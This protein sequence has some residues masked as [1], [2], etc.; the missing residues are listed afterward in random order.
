MLNTLFTFLLVIFSVQYSISQ[1]GSIDFYNGTWDN[2]TPGGGWGTGSV[3]TTSLGCGGNATV[4]FGSIGSGSFSG[5]GIVVSSAVEGFTLGSGNS[6]LIDQI[7]DG[8]VNTVVMDVVFDQPLW[9]NNWVLGDID[10]YWRPTSSDKQ[11]QEAVYIEGWTS[12]GIGALGTGDVAPVFSNPGSALQSTGVNAAGVD[13]WAARQLSSGQ[14]ALDPDAEIAFSLGSVTTPITAMRLYLVNN[15]NVNVSTGHNITIQNPSDP[16]PSVAS[17]TLPI[18]LTSFEAIR[19]QLDVQL[20]WMTSSEMNN[21]YFMIQRSTNAMEWNEI[22]MLRGKGT[23][24]HKNSYEFVDDFPALGNNYYRLMQVDFDGKERFS[25]V[26]WIEFLEAS[27][28]LSIRISPNP[29]S[30]IVTIRSV[31]IKKRNISLFDQM[32]KNLTHLLQIDSI[33]PHQLQSDISHLNNG[34]YFLKCGSHVRRI[35]KY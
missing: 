15:G 21:D 5:V 35:V 4:S 28:Q 3:G 9:I 24:I 6:E 16:A 30:N 34:I 22:G 2:G 23:T 11:W 19:G 32:G 27:N 31:D 14:P 29:A 26:V 7:G 8:L 18:Q 25:N 33:S 10:S 13:G 17:S 12:G 1:C 20:N